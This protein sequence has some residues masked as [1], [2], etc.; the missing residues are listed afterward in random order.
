MFLGIT[1]EKVKPYVNAGLWYLK[2]A[3]GLF[4]LFYTPQ[5]NTPKAPCYQCFFGGFCIQVRPSVP[6]SLKVMLHNGG[7]IVLL[8]IEE[9]KR[10]HLLRTKPNSVRSILDRPVPSA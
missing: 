8:L 1:I 2:Y 10:Q 3:V 5:A 9:A 4:T 6:T 7:Y